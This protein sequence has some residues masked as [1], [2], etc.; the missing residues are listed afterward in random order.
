V[1]GAADFMVKR[2]YALTWTPEFNVALFTL[3][4]NYPWEF[5]QVPLFERMPQTQHWDAVKACSRTAAGDAVIALAAYGAVA[6]TLRNR[7]GVVKPTRRSDAELHGVGCTRHGGHRTT[8]AVRPLGGALG[9]LIADAGGARVGS[10]AIATTAVAC[11]P[12]AGGMGGASTTCVKTVA[13]M[14]CTAWPGLWLLCSQQSQ[15]LAGCRTASNS[16]RSGQRRPH[17]PGSA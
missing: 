3:L 1:P 9:L 2:L 13:A 7:N 8:R 12:A 16:G 5:L 15:R 11:P 4:L 17:G 10:R 14:S 6:L